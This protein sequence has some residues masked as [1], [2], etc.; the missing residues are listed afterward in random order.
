MAKRIIL[1]V[2]GSGKTYYIC[3]SIDLNKKNLILAFTH[4]KLRNIRRE[5]YD[6]NKGKLPE[7]TNVMTFDS[8][9]YS[10]ML[11]PYEPTILDFFNASDI[12]TY[13]LTFR[14]PPAK[15]LLINNMW[16]ANPLYKSKDKIGHYLTSKGY[17]YCE[18]LSELILQ[19]KQ[20]KNSL[21]KR[22]AENASIFYDQILVDEFQDFREHDYDLICELAKYAKNITLIGDYYQHSVSAN[23][24]TGRPFQKRKVDVPYKDFIESLKNIFIVDD[25]SMQ[26]S[27]RCSENI[28]NFVSNKLKIRIASQKINNGSVIW[29][30]ENQI[31]EILQNSTIVKLVYKDSSKYLFTA[32]NWSYSKGDTFDAACVILTDKFDNLDSDSFNPS[33]IEQST[34]NKLYVALTR[35]KGNLFLIKKLVFD[36]VKI[37]YLKDAHH[38]QNKNHR[39]P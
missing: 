9:L 1:A 31:D 24:N 25:S 6:A 3:H 36:K 10:Y 20:G 22:I 4:E 38:A 33:K 15:Q 18:N 2:A 37:K 30:T 14:E 26:N 8:F 34:I 7:L 39:N 29:V 32:L 13:G 12:S 35:S 21:I 16:R 5:L 17:Y 28:C 27:R 11:Q 19:V 23:K